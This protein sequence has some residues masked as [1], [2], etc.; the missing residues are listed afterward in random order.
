MFAIENKLL[1]FSITPYERIA[2]N[3]IDP[4]RHRWDWIKSYVEFS[5]SGLEVKFSTE[6]TIGE[7]ANLKEELQRLETT[8]FKDEAYS[9]EFTPLERRVIMTFSS[10]KQ[11]EG[12]EVALLLRPENHADSVR[13][14]D[15]FG[16]D[17]SYFADIYR[18]I[19][20]MLNWE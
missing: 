10:N 19:D 2:D 7:L 12:V 16:I 6:F 15:E 5:V 13:V 20:E 8:L 11:H 14:S 17:Q 3:D 1:K 4:E 18:R 9:F